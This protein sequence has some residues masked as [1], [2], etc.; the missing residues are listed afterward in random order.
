MS[1]MDEKML[2]L[3]KSTT[4]ALDEPKP[5]Y[6]VISAS[7][8]GT[9]YLESTP[10]SVKDK[11]PKNVDPDVMYDHGFALI[12]T[13]F[14]YGA[15]ASAPGMRKIVVGD[16]LPEGEVT[17]IT[18][19][20]I[21]VIPDYGNEYVIPLGGRPGYKPP[22]K[23]VQA[24]PPLESLFAAAD[25]MGVDPK[26]AA[27]LKT[28]GPFKF[29]PD[30]TVAEVDEAELDR[31]TDEVEKKYLVE[32]GLNESFED[33][34]A[35][36]YRLFEDIE[37]ID[38]EPALWYDMETDT[39]VPY[40]PEIHGGK[41]AVDKNTEIYGDY[42]PGAEDMSADA[43]RE[44]SFDA[45]AKQYGQKYENQQPVSESTV[46]FDGVEYVEEVYDDGAVFFVPT[47][48]DGDYMRGENKKDAK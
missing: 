20:G 27:M 2:G 23:P 4:Q 28:A 34:K 41:S 45:A 19:K 46:E 12:E 11:T 24:K 6:K 21:K 42:I 8:Y 29:N 1:E 33:V 17:G 14:G 22:T 40:D 9:K 39:F 37:K 13:E 38:R 7:P 16:S 32:H 18:S 48:E 43:L 47:G 30:G 31:L 44:A 26:T 10:H 15:P 3:R 25:K 35:D 5:A 36:S